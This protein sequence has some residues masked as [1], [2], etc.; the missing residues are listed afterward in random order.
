MKRIR[1]LGRGGRPLI[2]LA[3]GGVLFGI[4]TAV[5]ASIPD[6]SGL[7]HGCYAKPGTPQR[8]QLR[9]IDSSRGER[10]LSTENPLNWS[11]VGPPGSPGVTGATGATG[12][13]GARGPT[14]PAGAAGLTFGNYPWVPIFG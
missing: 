2:A 7:I 14:G 6:G 12:P 13:S 1:G 9:V 11:Q 5:Q 4:A 10:C 3:V 8:G